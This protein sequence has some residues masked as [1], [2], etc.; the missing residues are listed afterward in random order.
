MAKFDFA[1][2]AEGQ[3]H[4]ENEVND[5]NAEVS[6][7]HVSSDAIHKVAKDNPKMRTAKNESK[8]NKGEETNGGNKNSFIYITVV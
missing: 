4:E 2:V 8:R 1:K 6:P 7:T 5:V 3:K